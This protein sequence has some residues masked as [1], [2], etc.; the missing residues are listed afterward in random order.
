VATREAFSPTATRIVQSQDGQEARLRYDAGFLAR[1]YE[2]A[3]KT[4]GCCR[5]TTIFWHA[6]PSSVADVK[7]E[8]LDHRHL[9]LTY[10]VRS[11][12]PQHCEK[13]LGDISMVCT[14]LG[15]C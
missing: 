6:G 4:L 2:V 14:P 7:I 11:G 3:L 13:Q 8:W 5:H 15:W 1:D 10:H 12:D 9:Q